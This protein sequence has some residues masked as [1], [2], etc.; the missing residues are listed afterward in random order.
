MFPFPETPYCG[1]FS[2]QQEIEFKEQLGE[3]QNFQL[4]FTSQFIL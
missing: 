3:M 4:Q 1:L 2:C